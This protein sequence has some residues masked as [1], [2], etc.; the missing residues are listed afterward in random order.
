M[1]LLIYYPKQTIQK[2][3]NSYN[4]C[5]KK[6]LK[7]N[8]EDKAP[9][10]DESESKQQDDEDQVIKFNKSI[11][12]FKLFSFQHR[13]INNLMNFPKKI[14]TL[15]RAP[16]ILKAALCRSS[17]ASNNTV[18]NTRTTRRGVITF[19]DKIEKYSDLTFSF[20]F[21]KLINSF[22]YYDFYKKNES[23]ILTN[24]DDIFRYFIHIFPK[25]NLNCSSN[26]YFKKYAKKNLSKKNKK[27]DLKKKKN[28][29]T[30]TLNNS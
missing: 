11:K 28:S 26:V 20:F 6:L 12:P 4:F 17:N 7:I 27:K 19:Q 3:N 9:K 22:N 13:V 30:L 23:S 16:S 15:P 14:N 8:L 24:L 29:L 10:D 1:S 18:I 5:I 25:F 21:N 2:L